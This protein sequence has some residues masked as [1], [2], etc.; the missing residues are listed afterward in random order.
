ME[1]HGFH[2]KPP[3]SDE[4]APEIV[5]VETE[6]DAKDNLVVYCLK[7]HKTKFDLVSAGHVCPICHDKYIGP[8]IDENEND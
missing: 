7:G 3:Y 4:F 1:K 5:W 6:K 8:M 2:Y